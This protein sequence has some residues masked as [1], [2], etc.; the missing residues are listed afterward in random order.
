M[1]VE[2]RLF[3]DPRTDI[4]ELYVWEQFKSGESTYYVPDADGFVEGVT[5]PDGGQM[6]PL[7]RLR[8]RMW[9]QV[10]AELF[11]QGMAPVDPGSDATK[12]H[13]SDAVEVRDRLLAL[14]ER[15]F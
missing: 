2:V 6:K 15:K 11:A 14:V 10:C 1:S 3:R 12:K 8:W 5:I 13:L 9:P 4:G 7:V